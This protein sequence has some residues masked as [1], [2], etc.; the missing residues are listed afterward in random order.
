MSE[1]KGNC[2][3]SLCIHYESCNRVFKDCFE[4]INNDE[5]RIKVSMPIPNRNMKL[6]K[7][8]KEFKEAD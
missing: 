8:M 1:K 3:Y 2:P 4:V 7:Y 6:V 5:V